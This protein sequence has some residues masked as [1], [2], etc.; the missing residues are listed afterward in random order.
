[1]Q[2]AEHCHVPSVAHMQLNVTMGL[3][4]A[5]PMHVEPGV[6]LPVGGSP[7]HAIDMGASP[8]SVTTTS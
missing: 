3:H 6:Q 1:M 2:C 7:L 4:R 5:D 8:A